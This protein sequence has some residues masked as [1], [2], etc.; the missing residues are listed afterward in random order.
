MTATTNDRIRTLTE[1]LTDDGILLAPGWVGTV[2]GFEGDKLVVS[3]EDMETGTTRT[4]TVWQW[5]IRK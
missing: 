2:I 5:E 4:A 3:F 1:V